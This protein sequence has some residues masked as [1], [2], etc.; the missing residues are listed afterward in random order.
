M[1]EC[2]THSGE[3]NATSRDWFG[4][5]YH[6]EGEND[7]GRWK[8]ETAQLVPSQMCANHSILPWMDLRPNCG[9]QK[10][11]FCLNNALQCWN[12]LHIIF[13]FDF[14]LQCCRYLR[15]GCGRRKQ[16]LLMLCARRTNQS[17]RWW[18]AN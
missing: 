3:N 17:R 1:V 15:R 5:D 4:Q 2:L 14:S 6:A 12:C 13:P 11:Y 9:S 7:E 8:V 10:V 18:K 16:T